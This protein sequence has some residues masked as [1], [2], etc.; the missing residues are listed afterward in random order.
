MIVELGHFALILAFATSLVQATLPIIGSRRS[1]SSFMDIAPM[2]AMIAFGL[3]AFSYLMLTEAYIHSDFSVLNVW[4]NSHSMMPLIFKITGVWGNHEGSMMLWVLILVFFGAMVAAFGNDLPL[5]VKGQHTRRSGLDFSG[6]S[7]I[8]SSDIE[9]L[10]E[11]YPAP[12][13]GRELNPILQDFGLAVHPPLLYLGYVGFSITF[14]FAVA[15]LIEGRVDAAWARWVRP[16]ALAA[17]TF[18]TAGICMGSYWSYYELGWGGWWFWDPVENAAF[19]PWLAG[20]R[21]SP[22]GPRCR[23]ARGDEDLDRPAGYSHFFFVAPWNIS[24]AVG[25]VDVGPRVRQRPDERNIH[26]RNTYSIHRRCL[27]IVRMASLDVK[28]RW[29]FRASIA[30]R[31]VNLQ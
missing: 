6:L 13:E 22:F 17:W 18:L 5:D 21:A 20:A 28:S 7:R 31:G 1:D 8:H 27:R 25:S 2:C 9:F 19:M 4:Q 24:R 10:R 12:D 23:K 16:W 11:A 3:V 29:T 26:S 14:A 15:A 30:R